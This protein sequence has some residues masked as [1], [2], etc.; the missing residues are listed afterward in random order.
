MIKSFRDKDTSEVFKR[1][2]VKAF[3]PDLQR[4]A[5]RKL[6]VLHAAN[7][8]E[9]LKVLPGNRLEKLSGKRDGQYSIRINNQWRL[10]FTWRDGDAWEAQITD[11]H[12]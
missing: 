11:Y 10:C 5:L 6:E 4:N 3:S 12:D 2:Y 9:D 8:L 1:K 7:S